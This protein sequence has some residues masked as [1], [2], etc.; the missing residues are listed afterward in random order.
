MYNP[1]GKISLSEIVP[2]ENDTEFRRQTIHGYVHDPAAA[3]LGGVAG[4]AGLFSDS[5]SLAVIMQM[6]MNG[7]EYGGVRYFKK[8][9]VNLFT[10][11]YFKVGENRRGLLFDKQGALDHLNGNLPPVAPYST[12]GH[13]GFTGTAAWADPENDLVFIFLSNRVQPDAKVNKLAQGNYRTD[14]MQAIYDVILKSPAKK[15]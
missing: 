8:E 13:T 12:F 7:G 15:N 1:A 9:T 14:I 11:Q 10:S 4:H 6:L 2:T 3:M 5:Y